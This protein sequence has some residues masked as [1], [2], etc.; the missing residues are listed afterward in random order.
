MKHSSAKAGDVFITR[1]RPRFVDGYYMQPV[2]G[3]SGTGAIQSDFC[4]EATKAG[5]HLDIP[6]YTVG[7]RSV[8]VKSSEQDER[9]KQF[10]FLLL[11]MFIGHQR[12]PEVNMELL[13]CVRDMGSNLPQL[14]L[15]TV[16]F[17]MI[18]SS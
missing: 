7:K 4:R 5:L 13:Q 11:N 10:R 8:R 2:D 3:P 15:L 12:V 1:G 16:A 6:I 9:H 18:V 17:G 14:F